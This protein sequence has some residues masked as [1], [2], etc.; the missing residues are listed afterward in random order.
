MR[1]CQCSQAQRHDRRTPPRL[2]SSFAGTPSPDKASHMP[3]PTGDGRRFLAPR[4]GSG[5]DAGTAPSG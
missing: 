3:A 5:D 1:L 4:R 2:A